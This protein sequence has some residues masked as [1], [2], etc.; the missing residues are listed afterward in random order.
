MSRSGGVPRVST[1]VRIAAPLTAAALVLSAGS[2][3]VVGL[4]TVENEP[5][6]VAGSG[7]FTAWAQGSFDRGI[8]RVT[9][10]MANAQ[11]R[12]RGE[13]VLGS[14]AALSGVPF[15]AL[16]LRL[17]KSAGPT[18]DD[19]KRGRFTAQAIV[20]YRLKVD[21]VRVGRR[22]DAVFR[23]QDGTW[24]LVRLQPSG[25]DL[26]DHEAVQTLRA[27]RVLV[28][29]PSGDD[30][31]QPLADTAKTARADVARF[32]SSR[33]PGTAV[34]VLPSSA[35]LLDPLL[36]TASGSD[37][38][39]VTRWETGLDGP[40][41]RVL[42]NPMYYDRMLPLAREIVLR[43]EITHVAQDALPQG[44]TPNWLSEGLAEYVGYRG[45]G[46]P[47]AYIAPK[48]FEQVRAEG[49][50]DDLPADSDFNFS[51]SQSERRIAY[52]S[53]WAFCQMV[54]ERYGDDTLVPFYVAVAKGKGSEEDRLDAAAQKVM[55]TSFET[56]RDQ[57][58]AWLD[59][60]A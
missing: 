30:R 34:V 20:E 48:L 43:H 15:T 44:G 12:S 45:S 5:E 46:V 28:I 47:I 53:G 9:N 16:D 10:A 38:V 2:G 55:D 35:N 49:A 17:A 39:A 52:E 54:A 42:V 4:N 40:I 50:P 1:A 23:L 27:G 11:L 33:W 8:E 32:W 29:G 60:N 59:A 19:A 51:R 58:R 22:A 3:F 24:R 36:G 37:Q 56:L 18:A 31:L 26:W 21:G 13:A 57:W 7:A 6:P 41:I 14:S 25:L